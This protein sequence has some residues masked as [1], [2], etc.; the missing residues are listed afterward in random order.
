MGK[1]LFS[2]TKIQKN[3]NSIIQ[4]GSSNVVVVQ[5]GVP[6]VPKFD[7]SHKIDWSI[8]KIKEM[9][10]I[11]PRRFGVKDSL[12]RAVRI[13]NYLERILFWWRVENKEV[14]NNN[15][16][17]VRWLCSAVSNFYVSQ[18]KYR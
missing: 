8:R 11:C 10:E 6:N 15:L 14:R 1:A 4:N 9:R 5:T 2:K 7:D 18:L 3:S 17:V 16:W 12:E 13:D